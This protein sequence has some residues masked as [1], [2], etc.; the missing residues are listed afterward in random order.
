MYE[1]FF[2][3][4]IIKINGY[5]YFPKRKHP[6]LYKDEGALDLKAGDDLLSHG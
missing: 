5:I 6:H 4:N 3:I 1:V 2:I